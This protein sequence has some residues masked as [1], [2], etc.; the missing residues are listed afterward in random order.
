MFGPATVV[1]FVIMFLMKNMTA[2]ISLTCLALFFNGAVAASELVNIVDIGPNYSGNS[3]M[4]RV[5]F[6]FIF[7]IYFI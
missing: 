3:N 2:F 4:H 7:F 5:C 1:F 6:N